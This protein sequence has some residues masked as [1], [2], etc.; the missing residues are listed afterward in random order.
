MSS[1]DHNLQP[2]E[3]W[4]PGV[5]TQMLVSAANGSTQLCIFEQLIEPAAGTP[6]HSHPVEEILTV[7]A[8]EAEVW[9][10]Q[11][12][13]ILTSGQ[14]LIVP[15]SQTHTFLNVSST[16]L[17]MR[18]VLASAVFEATFVGSTDTVRRW[19]H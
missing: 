10:D 15:A 12:R 16:T 11:S 4:R 14:S 3:I 13:T 19:Q 18:A 6:P 5:E 1:L 9:V 17:H 8:G 7:L 2:R